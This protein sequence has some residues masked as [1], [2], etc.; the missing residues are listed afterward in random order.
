MVFDFKLFL[1]TLFIRERDREWAR[2]GAG[3]SGEEQREKEK[4]TPQPAGI[5]R[6]LDPCSQD[7]N[8]DLSQRQ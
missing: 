3:G 2:A 1:K 4:Q 6:R 5:P 7:S 8:H